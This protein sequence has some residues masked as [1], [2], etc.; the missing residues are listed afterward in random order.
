M[1]TSLPPVTP[2]TLWGTLSTPPPLSSQLKVQL[3]LPLHFCPYSAGSPFTVINWQAAEML[4]IFKYAFAA[5]RLSGA[6]VLRLWDATL[7]VAVQRT[8]MNHVDGFCRD[9]PIR[10]ATSRSQGYR[11]SIFQCPRR[12][13]VSLIRHSTS[14]FAHSPTFGIPRCFALL[15]PI[16]PPPFSCW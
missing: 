2:A 3:P 10:S 12:P 8:S 14:A 16:P 15:R 7:A 1:H 9:L 4:D 13:S 6:V 11:V 5:V